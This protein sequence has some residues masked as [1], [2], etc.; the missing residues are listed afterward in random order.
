MA[1]PRLAADP[2]G[3][4]TRCCPKVPQPG[5][6]HSGTKWGRT[7][8]NR[9]GCMSRCILYLKM[10]N[11]VGKSVIYCPDERG[12][13]LTLQKEIVVGPPWKPKEFR[14]DQILSVILGIY[15][16]YIYRES[17]DSQ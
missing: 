5:R 11:K 16:T 3:P 15:R 13:S 14:S 17:L 9:S 7:A 4:A 6:L 1:V 10:R 12:V 2:R 8:L